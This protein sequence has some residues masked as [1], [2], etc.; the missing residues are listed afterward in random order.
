LLLLIGLFSIVDAALDARKL[1]KVE[2]HPYNRWYVY[3]AIILFHALMIGPL[4]KRLIT[5]STSA[6]SI[7]ARSM[8]PTLETGDRLISD[9][10]AYNNRLP[11]RRD[12]VIFKYP[13]DESVHYVKRVIGLPGEKL[14]IVRRMVYINDQPLKESYTQYIDPGSINEHWGPY[15]I[16]QGR[17]FVL[18]DNRDNSQ[19]SRFWG[20]ISQSKIIG[21]ARYLYWAKN[22]SR[23][24]KR[25]E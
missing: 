15:I 10:R 4:Q 11:A 13:N 6:Y 19:D 3:I 17:Y 8:I 25:L 1:K 5:Y 22:K 18:G 16:P 24:G 2:L 14:E 20:Y 7:P 21:Q 12:I 9:M 23:I